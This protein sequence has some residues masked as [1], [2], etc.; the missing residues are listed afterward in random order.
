M[1]IY[2]GYANLDKAIFEVHSYEVEKET[3]KEYFLTKDLL[4]YLTPSDTYKSVP[5][6]WIDINDKPNY[7]R[8]MSLNQERTELLYYSIDQEDILDTIEY[9]RK[10]VGT[11][12]SM[13]WYDDHQLEYIEH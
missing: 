12:V 7:I 2:I 13:K 3:D 9:Q 5:K 10:Y 4:P 11:Q 6:H 1:E 8:G